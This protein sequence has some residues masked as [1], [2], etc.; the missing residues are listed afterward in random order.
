[1]DANVKKTRSGLRPAN[2]EVPYIIT[3]EDAERYLQKK[4]DAIVAVMNSNADG[5]NRQEPVQITLMSLKCSKKF[6]PFFLM[7]PTNTLVGKGK[8][9]EELQIFNPEESEGQTRIKP[10]L[11][12]LVKSFRYEKRDESVW[13]NSQW[14]SVL[15]IRHQTVQILKD[16]RLLKIQRFNKGKNSYVTCVIDPIRL[17]HDMLED[18]TNDDERFRVYINKTTPIRAGHA[19]YEVIR[20]LNKG[21]K[22][23]S[24]VK[25]EMLAEITKVIGT[26]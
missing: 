9:K 14:R 10:L 23:D 20:V 2:T 4:V 26:N 22:A 8:N 19:E 13:F 5:N 1:M 17:F 21:D 7:L 3:T 18:P 12:K 16:H 15:G 11:Y 6:H 25:E 24:S